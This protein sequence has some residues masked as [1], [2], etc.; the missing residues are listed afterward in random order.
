[1]TEF[2][3]MDHNDPQSRADMQINHLDSMADVW[4]DEVDLIS[5]INNMTSPMKLNPNVPHDVRDQFHKRMKEQIDAICRQSFLEGAERAVTM[6]QD[7]YRS[8]QH[9]VTFDSEQIINGVRID[10]GEYVLM[11]VGPPNPQCDF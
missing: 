9:R 10:P 2:G 6:V 4:A 11:R 3:R 7:E 1:M 5:M 8:L